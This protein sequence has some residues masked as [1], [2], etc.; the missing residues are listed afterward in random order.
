MSGRSVSIGSALSPLIL[1]FQISTGHFAFYSLNIQII[2][3]G[4]GAGKEGT[5][6]GGGLSGTFY[7]YCARDTDCHERRAATKAVDSEKVGKAWRL[8]QKEGIQD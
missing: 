2:Y 6:V 3:V 4:L 8:P 7:S 5:A 1:S